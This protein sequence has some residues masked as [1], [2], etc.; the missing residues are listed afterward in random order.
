[1]EI[2]KKSKIAST[3]E[4][5]YGGKTFVVTGS[6]SGIG[7]ETSRVLRV[8]GAKVIGVDR[9]ETEHVDEFYKTDL[10]D[11]SSIDALIKALVYC[12][13]NYCM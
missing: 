5:L 10:S 11:P 8:K 12:S 13:F 3:Y 7:A 4:E 9:N 1:M 2:N 6:A